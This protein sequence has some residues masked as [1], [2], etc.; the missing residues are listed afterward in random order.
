M[1]NILVVK[2][3]I[4]GDNSVSNSLIDQFIEQLS[5]FGSTSKVLIRDLSSEP[6][7]Q[8]DPARLG[9]LAADPDTRDQAQQTM[10][11]F[12]DE[13]IRELQ[14]AD[15][16]LI[17]APMYNFTVAAGLKAWFDHVARAGVT[18]RYTE[19][20]SVG[21]LHD[22]QVVVFATMGGVHQPGDADHLRPYLKTVLN[23]LGLDD[24]EFIAATGLN[25]GAEHRQRSLRE[26]HEHLIAV[27]DRVGARLAKQAASRE[28]A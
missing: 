17:G 26:V 10:V 19:Q 2:S 9:A 4:L 8:L 11:Q 13:L 20:G 6:I 27:A 21:L 1:S 7:P 24:V 15:L 12:S 16:V 28:A 3:S 14:Q 23:F 22:K 5:V 18:F 25:L